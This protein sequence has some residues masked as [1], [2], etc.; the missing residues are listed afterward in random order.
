M[1]IELQDAGGEALAGYG[2][3]DCPEI[4]GDE[5]ERGVAW[6]GTDSVADLAG[7]PVRLRVQLR[8][9]DLFTLRFGK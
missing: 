6:S 9:A 8:D 1:R 3:D 4:I 2:L 5:I 7:R